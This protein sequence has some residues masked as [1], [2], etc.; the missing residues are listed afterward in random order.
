METATERNLTL[1]MP[2]SFVNVEDDH[3]IV[4]PPTNVVGWTSDNSA[5]L[6]S[7]RWDIWKIPVAAGAQPVNLTVNGRKEQIRYQGRVRIDPDERGID[8]AKPQ[9]FSEMSEWTER[10]CYGGL[11][12]GQT[13]LKMLL[14]EDA[15]IGRLQK[16][17]KAD[18]W[19][20]SRETATEATALYVTNASLTGGRKFAD[21]AAESASYLWSSGAQLIDYVNT[22]GEKLQASLY[23]PANYEKG[24]QYPT[25]VYIYEIGRAHV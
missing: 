3:N 11:P 5:V 1:G 4:D 19:I 12:P 15:S 18:V 10:A 24:K 16:A 7:D 14:W 23:L 9:Y 8:L 25:I 13:G 2:V 6:I 20:Y 21:T 22:K 17:E